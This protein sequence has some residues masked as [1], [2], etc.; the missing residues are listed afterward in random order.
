M[1]VSSCKILIWV[2]LISGDLELDMGSIKLEKHA[3]QSSRKRKH[4]LLEEIKEQKG[5]KMIEKK[6]ESLEKEADSIT[7]SREERKL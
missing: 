3:D 5:K 2:I 4:F 1:T 6:A 7:G